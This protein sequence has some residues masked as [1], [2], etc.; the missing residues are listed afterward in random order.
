MWCDYTAYTAVTIPDNSQVIAKTAN[1]AIK[2]KNYQLNQGTEV[3]Y[4][5]VKT[6]DRLNSSE[7][8][9]LHL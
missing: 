6:L 9:R 8:N 1:K 5:E 7:K 4:T 3:K 2:M